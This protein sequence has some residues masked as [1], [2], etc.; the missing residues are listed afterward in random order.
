MNPQLALGITLKD[1]AGFDTFVVGDNTQL[2]ADLH[3]CIDGEGERF[4]YLWGAEGTGKSH[5]LQAACQSADE[6]ENTAVYLPLGEASSMG[7]EVLEDLESLSLVCI[8]DIDAVAGDAQWEEALFHLYNRLAEHGVRLI[9]TARH[10]PGTLPFRLADLR[11]RL[12]WGLCYQI[13]S[14]EEPE[15]RLLLISE[16]ERRGLSLNSETAD[17]ILKHT[18][19]DVGSLKALIEKLDMASLA[20]QRRLTIPFI[21][22]FL[23]AQAAQ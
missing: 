18:Q 1:T 15:K 19:R 14:L 21:K 20:A 16:A 11:S 17:Y 13:A 2:L 10:S 6:Q 9:T 5:L 7:P 8:D 12:G 23:D 22:S 3:R 4:I